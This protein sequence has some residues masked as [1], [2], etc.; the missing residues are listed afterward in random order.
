MKNKRLRTCT[1]AKAPEGKE[2]K[3]IRS[4]RKWPGT[5][6]DPLKYPVVIAEAIR[7]RKKGEP[8]RRREEK[9]ASLNRHRSLECEFAE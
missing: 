7:L 2:K 5:G 8:Q 4:E 6:A 1:K 3:K 9:F